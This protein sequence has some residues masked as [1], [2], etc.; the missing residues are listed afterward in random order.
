MS[1]VGSVAL[2][3]VVIALLLNHPK[4]KHTVATFFPEPLVRQLQEALSL[5]LLP[6]SFVETEEHHAEDS[7]LSSPVTFSVHFNGDGVGE[8]PFRSSSEFSG[9]NSLIKDTCVQM[10]EVAEMSGNDELVLQRL[11]DGN[12][13]AKLFTSTGRRVFSFLDIIDGGRLYVVPQGVH[14]VWPLGKV[15]SEIRPENCKSPIPGK[16]II[17]RQLSD[18]PRVFTIENF[19]SPEEVQAIIDHNKE[20][21]KP[22]EVGFAG[23]R[24]STRTSSTAWDFHSWA[25]KKIQRRAFDIA[26]LD[27]DPEL[28]DATQ[29]LRYENNEWYKPHTDWFDDKAYEGHD[30]KVKN[31]TNRFVTIFLYLSD[32]EEGGHTVFPLSSTHEGYNGEYLVHKG[33]DNTAGYIANND[34]KWVC[35]TSSTALRSAPVAGSAVMFYS[36]GPDGGLDKYSLHGGCP[37]ISGTKW[38]AN[39][40]LWNREKPGKEKALD[41][42]GKEADDSSFQVYFQNDRS[43]PIDLFWDDGTD[44]MIFQMAVEPGGVRAPITTYHGHRF[45]AKD[46]TTKEILGDFVA[47]DNMKGEEH[48]KYF[49]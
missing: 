23:W 43:D 4:S 17:M 30:P 36:Q 48:I 45:V 10:I 14:F 32:V 1:V 9:V 27:Y 35:N 8:S 31:G 40:W 19:M 3:A 26:G 18:S 25:A 34:A 29:V 44:D 7:K 5:E 42:D 39:V 2:I 46:A 13:G 11:C 37:V 24:D 28:A 22:S 47:N 49:N 21:V 33:T 16:P 6:V 20:L 38:S 15:G 41:G 12:Q